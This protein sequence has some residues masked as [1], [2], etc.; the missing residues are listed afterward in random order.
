MPG[1]IL[2][3]EDTVINTWIW[4]VKQNDKSVYS[5]MQGVMPSQ[6]TCWRLNLENS[7]DKRGGNGGPGELE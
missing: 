6:A 3:K 7:S 4:K 2:S 5:A 1:N